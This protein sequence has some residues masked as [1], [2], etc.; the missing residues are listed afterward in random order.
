MG[1]RV[2]S[3]SRAAY[4]LIMKSGDLTKTQ[5]LVYKYLRKYGPMTGPELDHQIAGQRSH[6]H[7]RLSELGD[8]GLAKDTG[9][10]RRN[11]G[12]GKRAVVWKATDGPIKAAPKR[13]T[14]SEKYRRICL[15]VATY[16]E[17]RHEGS[18]RS[19][20]RVAEIIRRYVVEIDS[21]STPSI[22]RRKNDE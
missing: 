4:H 10:R 1:K 19:G 18:E 12:T 7:K 13:L 6:Y 16:M 3:T 22:L 2:R 14:K 20:E 17:E 9:K 21:G 11:K 5:R 15:G 8:I